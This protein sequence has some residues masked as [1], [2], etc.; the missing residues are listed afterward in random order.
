M[1]ITQRVVNSWLKPDPRAILAISYF[2]NSRSQRV[3]GM[4]TPLK[5]RTLVI[6][7]A[8]ASKRRAQLGGGGSFTS[9]SWREGSDNFSPM[10]AFTWPL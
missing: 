6:S 2:R 1:L 10:A 9:G 3:M 8:K 4:A 7:A 5:S